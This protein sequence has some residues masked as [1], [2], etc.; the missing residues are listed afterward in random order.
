MIK[1]NVFEKLSIKSFNLNNFKK[2]YDLEH[3][4]E[5]NR[6]D[7]SSLINTDAILLEDVFVKE[8]YRGKGY[9]TNLVNELKKEGKPIILYS[10]FEAEEFWKKQGFTNYLS[11]VYVWGLEKQ[12]S[13]SA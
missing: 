2:Y 13:S 4:E 7:L 9:A 5:K 1:I 11:C 3:H 6:Y 10:L 8:R 12:P